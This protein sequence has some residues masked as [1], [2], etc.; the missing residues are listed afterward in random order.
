MCDVLRVYDVMVCPRAAIGSLWCVVI[1]FDDVVHLKSVWVRLHSWCDHTE[2]QTDVPLIM[3]LSSVIHFEE[4]PRK[5][6]CIFK[7]Y[8]IMHT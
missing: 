8:N 6:C 3:W 7:F 4:M 5:K 1:V 2:G